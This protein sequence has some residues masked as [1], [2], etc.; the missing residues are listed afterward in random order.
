MSR[1]VQAGGA[2]S[3]G[4]RAPRALW[5]FRGAPR[6]RGAAQAEFLHWFGPTGVMAS[7]L[8]LN[9]GAAGGVV[10]PTPFY[11]A[12]RFRMS[13]DLVAEGFCG[14]IACFRIKRTLWRSHMQKNVE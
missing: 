9:V 7:R 4:G 14:K 11:G 3:R 5:A 12:C 2:R 10:G 8:N 1:W 6:G 13:R